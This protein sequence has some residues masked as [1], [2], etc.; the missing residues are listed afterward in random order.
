MSEPKVILTLSEYKQMLSDI[1][2]LKAKTVDLDVDAN[3]MST[4]QEIVDFLEANP[5]KTLVGSIG[6]LD[7][8]TLSTVLGIAETAVNY[9]GVRISRVG[10][11]ACPASRI[12][13]I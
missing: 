1:D 4:L 13:A 3:N 8:T 11:N 7:G 12:N 6:K 5:T 9:I 2:E 10:K